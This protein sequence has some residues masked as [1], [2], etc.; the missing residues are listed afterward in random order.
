MKTIKLSQGKIALVDDEDYER[1]SRW[2]WQAQKEGNLR[3]YAMRRTQ[4]PGKRRGILM[5]REILHVPANL[6]TDHIDHNGL[7]NQKTNLRICTKTQNMG[8]RVR[9]R[10]RINK[11]KGVSLHKATQKW[12]AQIGV[13]GKRIY[14]GLFSSAI[15]AA[16]VYD[17]AAQIYFG[18]FALPNFERTA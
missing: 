18:E 17:A 2:K 11:Y 1:L 7:N 16:K 13:H 4:R 12:C 9:N 3:C 5:H 14:L 15:E 10:G 8:N 6:E